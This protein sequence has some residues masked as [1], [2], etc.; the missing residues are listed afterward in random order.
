MSCTENLA[1]LNCDALI[2]FNKAYQINFSDSNELFP[3]A[4]SDPKTIQVYG[5]T[6]CKK[7]K[8]GEGGCAIGKAAE[9]FKS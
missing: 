9:P 4:K 8:K 5:D 2:D 7:P 1:N 3:L 6:G